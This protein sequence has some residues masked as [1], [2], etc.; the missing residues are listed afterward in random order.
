MGTNRCHLYASLPQK[1]FLVL[2]G[3]SSPFMRLAQHLTVASHLVQAKVCLVGET[4]RAPPRH[5]RD[6]MVYGR[7]TTPV[8]EKSTIPLPF[9]CATHAN[10]HALMTLEGTTPGSRTLEAFPH[11]SSNGDDVALLAQKPTIC[12]TKPKLINYGDVTELK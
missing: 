7:M 10:K 12:P 8:H 9:R 5:C 4:Q 1:R 6:A 3:C 11:P 2:V